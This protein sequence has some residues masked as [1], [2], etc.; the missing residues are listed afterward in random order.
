MGK[1]LFLRE[2]RSS[3]VCL[4]IE[5]HREQKRRYIR[6]RASLV[7]LEIEE[8]YVSD[9]SDVQKCY[10]LWPVSVKML[11]FSVLRALMSR[12]A[13]DDINGRFGERAAR[14]TILAKLAILAIF[15]Q[16]RQISSSIGIDTT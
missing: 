16:F 13:H 7:H 11:R 14:L 9:F 6:S 10:S 3:S 4:G 8:M 12:I 1:R 5:K 15:C 2:R